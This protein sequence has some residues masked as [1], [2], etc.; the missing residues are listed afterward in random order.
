MRRRGAMAQ[1]ERRRRPP[2]R[3]DHTTRLRALVAW[4][5]APGRWSAR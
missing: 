5:L 3:I 2:R 1:A 4:C